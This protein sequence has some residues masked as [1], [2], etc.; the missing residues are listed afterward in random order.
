[1]ATIGELA[2][3]IAESY[4]IYDSAFR[5]LTTSTAI[6]VARKTIAERAA[7]EK[8]SIATLSSYLNHISNLDTL[9]PSIRALTHAN[10]SI[11]SIAESTRLFD[12]ATHSVIERERCWQ[13]ITKNITIS[14]QVAD[15]T[16]KRHTSSMLS[17]SLAAQ[18]KMIQLD[19][20]R[21]GAAIQ[22]AESFDRSFRSFLDKLTTSYD[23]LFDFI[24]SQPSGLAYLAP[25]VTQRPPLEIY[26]EAD[27]L[28]EITIPEN[29]QVPPD[30]H[31][32][33][34]VSEERPLEDW[35][36]QIDPNLVNLLH[37]ARSAIHESNPDRA[38]HVT[39]SL[40]E[41]FTHVIHLLAPDD[42]IRTWTNAYDLYH[43]GRPTRRAKLLYINRRINVDPLSSFV[44]SDVD[45]AITLID[46]LNAETHGITSRLTERQLQAMVY[47]I[48]YLLLFLF[49][50]NATNE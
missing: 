21:L 10:A 8:S 18:S 35:L 1:M 25:V 27:L 15:L 3:Q 44:N 17:A 5:S 45:S 14:N 43:N 36:Q 39:T 24:G 4:S 42:S 32:I 48:E 23:R 49:H 11:N 33:A 2:R 28:E 41:L 37:G 22:A 31:D 29:E 6:D 50:L 46:A 16:L 20:Y 38:R 13:E 47:R 9:S 40:R 26:R 34:L 7:F 19:S 30:E 12:S